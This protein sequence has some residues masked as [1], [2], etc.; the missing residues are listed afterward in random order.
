MP[1]IVVDPPNCQLSAP[2]GPVSTATSRAGPWSA[3]TGSRVFPAGGLLHLQRFNVLDQCVDAILD[4][5][6]TAS[7]SED[8]APHWHVGPA[9]AS[10]RRVTPV[11]QLKE[12]LSAGNLPPVFL[13]MMV[14][15]AGRIV[16]TWPRG[17]LPLPSV[18]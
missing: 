15:L 2:G 14:R 7:C 10:D 18:P 1:H 5:R 17:P 4:R 13:A 8:L 12:I 9:V 11:D 3:N 16:S 6:G